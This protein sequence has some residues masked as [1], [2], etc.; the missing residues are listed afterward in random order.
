M[1]T[2]MS[3]MRDSMGSLEVPDGALYGASTQRAINNFPVSG[4]R[5]PVPMIRMLGLVKYACAEVNADLGRLSPGKASLIRDAARE[6]FEGRHDDQF[7]VDIFQ[8]GSGTST[9]MNANEV[10]AVRAMQLASERH[11]TTDSIHPNDD[12]NMGQSSNDIMPSALNIS[13]S[14]SAE[15]E[16][17]PALVDLRNALSSKS[18]EF[19]EVLK[20]GR[21]HLMDATPMTMGQEF[22]GY[23]AQIS[24]AEHRVRGIIKACSPLAVGGTAI[25]T[26]LATTADLGRLVCAVINRELGTDF[27]ETDNHFAAQACRDEAV[28]AAGLL[29]AVAASLRKIANDIRLLASG[30]RCGLGELTLPA[31]QPGSSIMPGKVNPVLCESVVQVTHHVYGQ[32]QA[33]MLAGGDGQFE[34]NANIPVIAYNLLES[35]RLLAAVC[36]QFSSKCIRG[37]EVN[38]GQCREYVE[39]SLMLATNLSRHIGYDK[40]AEVAKT[41][42]ERGL[43]LREVVLERGYLDEET[44][45]AALSPYSMLSPERAV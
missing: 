32:C 14:W 39:R 5:V 36:R 6:I 10:I 9:N 43:T 4:Y 24:A 13:V 16:L 2:A 20:S 40:A 28:E 41:A 1:I 23:A 17:L 33:T 31:L 3:K 21:T 26:G 7:P 35:I 29:V 19:K 25:G 15:T 11:V 37:I 44:V 12:V 42:Q 45:D 8:T 27:H 22:S 38:V 34:L 18:R 30:P